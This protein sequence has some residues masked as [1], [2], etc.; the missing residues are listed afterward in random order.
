[1]A[2]T[3]LARAVARAGSR[4]ALVLLDLD[5]FREVNDTLGHDRGD[6]LVRHMAGRLA[7]LVGPADLVARTGGDEFA[8]LLADVDGVESAVVHA[9]VLR[10]LNAR[11]PETFPLRAG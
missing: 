4:P 5:R 8:V 11:F 7:G 2:A 9:E 3:E 1:M 6:E 10:R